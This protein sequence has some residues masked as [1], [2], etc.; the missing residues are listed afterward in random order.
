MSP[1]RVLGFRGLGGIFFDD[2]NDRPQDEGPCLAM[3]FFTANRLVCFSMMS[4][5]FLQ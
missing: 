4:R 1:L 3:V 2:L 5:I